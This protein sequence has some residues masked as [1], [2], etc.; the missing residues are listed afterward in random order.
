MIAILIKNTGLIL[1][2]SVGNMEI[3]LI[4]HG[5]TTGDIEDR[6]GG[7]YDDHLS[8][9]GIEESEELAQKLSGAGI[10]VIYTSPKSRAIETSK[11]VSKALNVRIKVVDGLRERNNYGILTG[12]KKAEA[13]EKHPDQVTEL[14]TGNNHNVK[15]SENYKHFKDRVIEIFQDITNDKKYEKVAIITH[16][17]PIRCIVRETLKLGELDYLSDCAIINIEFVNDSYIL[18]DLYGAMLVERG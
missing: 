6:Y 12:M 16:G 3:C 7:D 15:D 14:Q 18:G 17:G 1:Q 11:I 8:E 5:E 2:K 10:Q 4:S 13:I 9:R